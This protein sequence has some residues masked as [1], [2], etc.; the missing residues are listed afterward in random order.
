MLCIK[1]ERKT[2]WAET[3]TIILVYQMQL[4]PTD[5]GSEAYAIRIENE[6]TGEEMFILDIT[7]D[8]AAAES[9]FCLL[10][11][12]AVTPVTFRDVVEDFVATLPA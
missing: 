7:E 10:I 2:I 1:N 11:D 12:G 8:Q 6:T 4:L 9:L 5:R 3:G